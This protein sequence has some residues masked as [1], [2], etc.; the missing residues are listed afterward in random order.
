M[1]NK[2]LSS[3]FSL[4]KLIFTHPI[5]NYKAS[6]K[7]IETLKIMNLID[8]TLRKRKKEFGFYLTKIG[9][10]STH[11]IYPKLWIHVH[12]QSINKKSI[13]ESENQILNSINLKND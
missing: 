12:T 2:N 13:M 7:D 8:Q 10:F 5:S 1:V 4:K 3:S 9:N 11:G 6:A